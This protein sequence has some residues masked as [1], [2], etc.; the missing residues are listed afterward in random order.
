MISSSDILNAR[1][2]IVDDQ[3]VN[4]RVLERML[5]G[6][7][8][9]SIASTTDPREVSELHRRKPLRPDPARSPD[10][11]HGWIPGDGRA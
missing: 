11:R 3:E 4:I 6:A 1:V 7:G 10:A 2:L 8:H 9:T 5:R